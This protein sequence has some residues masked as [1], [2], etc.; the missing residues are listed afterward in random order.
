VNWCCALKTAISD[1]EARRRARARARCP[2][3]LHQVD[4]L[5]LAGSTKVKV[6]GHAQPVEFGILVHFAYQ[7]EGGG[8]EIV[9]ATTRP[10][11]MLG[12]TAVAVHPDDARYKHLHGRFV[13]HPFVEGRRLP[14]ITDAELVDMSFGG[15]G[16]PRSSTQC[17]EPPARRHGRGEDHARARRQ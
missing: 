13:T 15:R 3:S 2:Q 4:Y 16:R 17:A 1:I 10:E 6:P 5:E 11:T 8:G 12:D 9:V 14:I 7:L